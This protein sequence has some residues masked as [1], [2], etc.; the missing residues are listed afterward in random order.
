M[1][2]KY[3]LSLM[4]LS[5]GFLYAAENVGVKMNKTIVQKKRVEAGCDPA[6][7]A[8]DLDINNVR[9]RIMNGGDMWWDLVGSARYE[10]PKVTEAGEIRRHSLFAGAL[11]I[12]GIEN[13]NLKLA[14]MTYRQNGSDFFPGPLDELGSTENS[15][16]QKYDK[17]Y[18]VT[19]EEIEN[20]RQDPTAVPPASIAK[21]PALF[22]S[23][24]GVK[25]PLAPYVDV[26]GNGA[27]N[28]IDGR[29]YPDV[30]GDQTLFYVYNDK[31][32]IHSESKADAIGLELQTQAFAFATSDEVNNMTFYNTIVYNRSK[33]TL[34]QT[35]FGQWV[36]SDLGY[37]FDD[38]VGCDTLRGL[39][40]C[41]N[42][43]NID[44]GVQGYG[45]NPPTV[46]V[47]FFKGPL[48]DP[49]KIDND[50]NGIVDDETLDMGKFVYY[51]NDFGTQGNPEEAQHY[52]NYLTAKWKNG[53]HV[54][55][56]KD[57]LN[58]TG[59]DCDFMFPSDPRDKSAVAWNEAGV[60]NKP[61]DRRFIQSAGPFTLKP[62]AKNVVTTGVVWARATSG[63]PTGSLSKLF[64]AD[65][66]AQELYNNNFT[67]TEGPDAPQLTVQELENKI[68]LSMDDTK[69]IESTTKKRT[70]KKGV[71]INYGFQGYQLY[72]L[73]NSNV[74]ASEL[75]NP[76]KAR[77]IAQV[78][79]KDKV[80]MLVNKEDVIFSNGDIG[81]MDVEKV[82]GENLGLKH[83]FE[84]TTDAFASGD[85]KLVNFKFY[86]FM[87]VSYANGS[88]ASDEIQYLA[89]RKT[90]KKSSLLSYKGVPHKT[91]P[92][93][94]GTKL[95][96]DYGDGPLLTRIEG[97]GN[98][99]NI[100]DLTDKS[101]QDILTNTKVDHPE[102]KGGFGPLTVKVFDPIAV[103]NAKYKVTFLDPTV[104]TVQGSWRI[105]NGKT[106]WKI[107]NIDDTSDYVLSDTTIGYGNEQ[108]IPKWG[109]S[110]SIKQPVAPGA[111][112]V[113]ETPN[114]LLE[115]TMTFK[116]DK[117]QWLTGVPDGEAVSAFADKTPTP[118]NW[119][120]SGGSG[121]TDAGY[122]KQVDDAAIFNS[123]TSVYNFVDPKGKYETLLKGIIAP[124]AVVAR[125]GSTS[126][127]NIT[128][129]PLPEMGY[130]ST[131]LKELQSVD[132][133][134]TNDKSKWTK[135]IVVEEGEA[136]TLNE[137][138]ANKFELRRH[139]N[140]EK[141]T[142]L[143]ADGKPVYAAYDVS[144]HGQSW[145]PGYAI[146]V[147]T[148]ERLNLII[149]EDS[150]L[151]NEN[152]DDLIWNPTGNY[153][154][155]AAGATDFIGRYIL[156]G[157]HW[158]YVMTSHN[159][160]SASAIVK[161][162]DGGETYKAALMNNSPINI[163][164]VFSGV[165]WV[166]EPMLNATYPLL[167]LKDGL[168]PTDVKIRLRVGT[169]YQTYATGT[170]PENKNVNEYTFNTDSIVKS[171][172]VQEGKD[173]LNL[174][175]IVPNPYYAFSTYENSQLDNR[176]RLT[177]LPPKCKI[178]IFT[179]SGSLVREFNIDQSKSDNQTTYQDWDLKNNAGIPIS[180][181]VYLI[182][183]DGFELG[184]RTIKWYGVMRP[185][186]LDTF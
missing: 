104:S 52:Y 10:V 69:I 186:D 116:N 139:G 92:E 119:I 117:I 137:Q 80:I 131:P 132:L 136:S 17:I 43:N 58:T 177:N 141:P 180:S 65:D 145:F 71:T 9:A 14:A 124:A 75:S 126:N 5:S 16:C 152:G 44:P 13:N 32:N 160:A 87:V 181:G 167:S 47:D 163:S 22:T 179:I 48:A 77:Q 164:R 172:S 31:G 170:A 2:K 100:L 98:G 7:A 94:G 154:N 102:Y 81:K 130:E 101:V 42:G 183:I 50:S 158:I 28:P 125:A 110:V 79:I 74:T 107:V 143:D 109:L 99:G 150:H 53:T 34:S 185:I 161:E 121:K 54:K 3:L 41:Y 184:S 25:R 88:D 169:Q 55:Y 96:S 144:N 24:A 78:D 151:P 33:S 1:Y 40:Y 82:N 6:S 148:G 93:F 62:G 12:G 171:T 56:G 73:K 108:V 115:A 106:T 111:D 66:K 91:N 86:Y 84:I 134:F 162:Y 38:Y 135:C 149:G 64:L 123:V 51:N 166:M 118:W 37:A 46:G 57:G 68:I 27:Y 157:K 103:K 176:V 168:I 120:R 8:V 156:G 49:D 72:Q 146:N 26:D 70:N 21:W 45:E 128:M 147:E 23:N 59:K 159:G 113:N 112:P 19:R 165:M 153:Y 61:G 142:D 97:T 67:I 20:F 39:G 36:D 18:E 122:V 173:A 76:D 178:S 11:W 114:G 129:G 174:S 175:N 15:Q 85:N 182:N 29:D 63:G 155:P 30:F 60:P 127:G 95:N 35:Y 133:V 83:T 90:Y 138:G 105:T 4:L 140:W 89:S